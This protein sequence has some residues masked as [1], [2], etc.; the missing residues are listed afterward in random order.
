[1]KKDGPNATANRGVALGHAAASNPTVLKTIG[2]IILRTPLGIINDPR[3]WI[4]VLLCANAL[5]ISQGCLILLNGAILQVTPLTILADWCG[6]NPWIMSVSLLIAGCSGLYS[7]VFDKPVF[8]LP[9]HAIMLMAAGS[10]LSAIFVGHYPDGYV[11]NYG[12]KFIAA[13]QMRLVIDV[14]GYGLGSFSGWRWSNE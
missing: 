11:P 9:Q 7:I 1:M 3:I 14:I 2:G 8:L 12:W 5:S 10:S 13:D 4:G 6:H